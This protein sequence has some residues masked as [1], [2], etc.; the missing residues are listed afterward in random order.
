MLELCSE[1]AVEVI[2]P[3]REAKK[4]SLGKTGLT[5]TVVS[6]LEESS[7]DMCIALGGD[8]TILRAFRRLGGSMT[9][10]L[11]INFGTIGFLAALGSSAIPEKLESVLVGEYS[12]VELCMLDLELENARYKA[13]NDVVLQKAEGT[14]VAHLGYEID[15]IEMDA[16]KCDGL[17][18]STPAGSTAYNLSNGG[19]MASLGLDVMILSAI[20]PHSLRSRAMILGGEEKLNISNRFGVAADAYVDGQKIGSLKESETASVTI[21][22]NKALLVRTE[23]TNFFEALRQK[24]IKP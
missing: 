16:F 8:G 23:E 15:G 17:V 9:P 10:V 2:I 22:K 20:A 18:V 12:V 6:S 11:G 14:S 5:A 7:V 24:F 13:V 19:P 3:E 1:R 4:H 21:S